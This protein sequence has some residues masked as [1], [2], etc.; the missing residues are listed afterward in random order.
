MK[1]ADQYLHDTGETVGQAVA[2]LHK[3]MTAEKAGQYIG[4]SGSTELRRYLKRRGIP[5]P[6]P[7]TK[8]HGRAK[9]ITPE[10]LSE[11]LRRTGDGESTKEVAKDLGFKPHSFRQHL[12]RAKK[13]TSHD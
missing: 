1:I 6:W 3:H 4:F 12:T 7:L 2:R 11:F 9:P 10:I 13:A 5:D 8:V